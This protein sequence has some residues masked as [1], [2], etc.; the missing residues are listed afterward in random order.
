M[1]LERTR[2]TRRR[3]EEGHN[4]LPNKTIGKSGNH[5]VLS[6][7]S[8]PRCNS[9][10]FGSERAALEA[11]IVDSGGSLAMETERINTRTKLGLKHDAKMKNVEIA[12]NQ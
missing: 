5:P 12:Q 10:G 6:G 3:A 8:G 2:S 7:R 4:L 9:R 1:A 11:G